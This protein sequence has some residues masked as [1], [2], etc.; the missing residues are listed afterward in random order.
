MDAAGHAYNLMSPAEVELVHSSTLRIL[1]EVGMEV[2]N[3]R[4]RKVMADLGLQVDFQ[5]Q[6]V[7]FPSPWVERFISE[8]EKQDWEKARP[9]VGG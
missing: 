4:L 9:R 6:R 8:A 2:Q 7:R 5:S 3:Q 1:R